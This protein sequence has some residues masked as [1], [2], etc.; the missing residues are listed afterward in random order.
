MTAQIEISTEG[1]L[2]VIALDR[3]EAINALTHAMIIAIRDAITMFQA[4]PAIRAILLEGRGTRGF[5]AGGD[6]R[7]IRSLVLD[8]RMDEARAFFA[9]EYA[10]NGL[11]AGSEKPVVA[12]THGVVMGGGIGLAGHAGFR[13]TTDDGRFAMP[14]GAIGF[15]SDV[16]SNAIL[17]KSPVQRALAFLLSGQAVGVADAVKLGLT[18]CVVPEAARERV[19]SGI[20]AAS[21]ADNVETSLVFLMQTEGVEPGEAPFC[22]QADR[23]ERAFAAT[24][25]VTLLEAL[26]AEPS[27]AALADQIAGRSPTSLAAILETHRAGRIARTIDDVLAVDLAMAHYLIA[28][29]DFAEGVRAVLVDKDHAPRWSPA[30]PARVAQAAIGEVVRQASGNTRD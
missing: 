25:T 14:E 15:F 20:I 9:D 11:I 28:Q 26:R 3:P 1:A 23:L 24:D 5:C 8:G 10:L 4:D 7:A 30:E 17:A 16:G 12:L 2:G 21:G 13:F 18:D 27:G 19:R 6:V 22:L 29:P